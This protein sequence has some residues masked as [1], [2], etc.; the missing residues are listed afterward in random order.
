MPATHQIE[1]TEHKARPGSRVPYRVN[2][3]R[4]GEVLLA[5]VRT[6][7]FSAAR[8]LLAR[9]TAAAGDIVELWRPGRDRR[10]AFGEVSALAKLTVEENDRTGPKLARYIPRPEAFTAHEEDFSAEDLDAAFA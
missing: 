8:E 4:T 1:I 10:D 3:R 5:S 9:G 7:L 6:P 2:D